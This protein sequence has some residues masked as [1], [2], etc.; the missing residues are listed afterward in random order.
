MVTLGDGN[1]FEKKT[2]NILSQQK[3]FVATNGRSNRRHGV[4]R[5]MPPVVPKKSKPA[6]KKPSQKDDGS[7]ED[8]E[9]CSP[10]QPT[11]VN[12]REPGAGD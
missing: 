7:A 6:G 5:P 8:P 3:H 1:F 10:S 9:V 4:S 12:R 11:H 2:K